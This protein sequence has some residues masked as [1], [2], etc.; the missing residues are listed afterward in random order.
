MIVRATVTY[1][2]YYEWCDDDAIQVGAPPENNSQQT[3][4]SHQKHTETSSSYNS[5]FLLSIIK[6]LEDRKMLSSS[7]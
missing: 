2:V 3:P 7:L 4:I 1:L 5:N 6:L